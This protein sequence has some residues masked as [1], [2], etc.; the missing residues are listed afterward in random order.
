MKTNQLSEEMQKI[1]EESTGLTMEQIKTMDLDDINKHLEK[2]IGRKLVFKCMF[3]FIGRKPAG[4]MLTTEDINASLDKS[5]R[6]LEKGFEMS[7]NAIAKHTEEMAAMTQDI[8]KE[9]N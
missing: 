2:K 8:F 6:E 9:K 1:I 4:I 7:R 5:E 3:P